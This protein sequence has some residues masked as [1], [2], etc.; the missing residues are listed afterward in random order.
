MHPTEG[1]LTNQIS[2]VLSAEA[3]QGLEATLAEFKDGEDDGS[4][5]IRSSAL[6]Q[7]A[8]T[9]PAPAYRLQWNLG[10][11]AN[12][13]AGV[14]YM[15]GLNPREPACFVML[16]VKSLAN[17]DLN[18]AAAAF[19]RAIAL[20]SPQADL[21]RDRAEGL[22]R[23]I[24]EAQRNLIPLYVLIAAALLAIGYYLFDLRRRRRK[25]RLKT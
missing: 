21:L 7:L 3:I 2:T 17:G 25:R 23:H 16:G 15:A 10:R 6:R 5:L 1:L 19:D 14:I 18:L 22:R 9:N 24:A 20:G 13:E 4:T 11:D 8:T 12:L